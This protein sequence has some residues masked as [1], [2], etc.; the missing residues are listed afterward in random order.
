MH[1]DYSNFFYDS[2]WMMGCCAET[3]VGVTVVAVESSKKYVNVLCVCVC[4]LSYP[5][6]SVHAPYCL[7]PVRI[8]SIFARYLRNGTT[9]EKK[10]Y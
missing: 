5:A 1:C 9:L 8:Y 6:C 4:S 7:W 2:R 3:R 10:S